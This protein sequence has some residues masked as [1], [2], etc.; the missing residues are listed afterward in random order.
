MFHEKI[1]Q[2]RPCLYWKR[3]PANNYII[4]ISL[5]WSTLFW[6]IASSLLHA[7]RSGSNGP[8][9]KV[10]ADRFLWDSF[11][12]EVVFRARLFKFRN[13]CTPCPCSPPLPP[14]AAPAPTA[15]NHR[16]A[17]IPSFSP[18][19][20]EGHLPAPRL[21]LI[22]CE[23]F[24]VRGGGEEEATHIGLGFLHPARSTTVFVFASQGR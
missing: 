20:L 18:L 5:F 8:H 7:T 23:R 24:L 3:H 11:A 21:S 13:P 9:K 15:R 14:I 1:T 6:T 16:R 19:F 17:L 4:A 10:S 2:I 12:C 22:P